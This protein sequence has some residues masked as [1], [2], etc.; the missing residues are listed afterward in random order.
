MSPRIA[1]LAWGSLVWDPRG[2][3]HLPPWKRDGP[4]ARVEFARQSRD[5]RITLVLEARGD[6]VP[7]L[8]A[9][10]PGDLEPSLLALRDREGITPPDW[11]SSIGCWRAGE[12]AP[13]A[14][15]DLPAWAGLRG[16]GAVIWTA[17]GPRY[18][19][20]SMEL[21]AC[22][23]LDWVLAHLDGLRG[24]ARVRAETYV[25][26]APAQI[27]TPYRR[28]IAALLGWV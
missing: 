21:L 20:R 11:R 23:P 2:L 4:A 8:W 22:P 12:A 14:I 17:L 10:M 15:P 19:T 9:E 18:E 6:P 25:R 24:E 13:A 7:L 5:G 16:L 28:A 3:P 27:D 26:R 1:C